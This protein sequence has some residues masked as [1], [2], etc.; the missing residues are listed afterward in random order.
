M[1]NLTLIIDYDLQ[2]DKFNISGDVEDSKKFV[3]TFLKTQT[4]NWTENEE[5]EIRDIYNIEIKMDNDIF[6][7]TD[8]CGNDVLRNGILGRYIEKC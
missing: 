4:N 8:N 5:T 3:S 2:K 1:N 7:V 6:H